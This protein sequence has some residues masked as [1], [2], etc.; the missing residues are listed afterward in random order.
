MPTAREVRENVSAPHSARASMNVRIGTA[1]YAYRSWVG[2]FYPP[3]TSSEKML[4]YYARHFPVVEINNS[5]YRPP[6]R[7]Q[8]ARMAGRTPPGFGFT[9]KAPRSVS[10]DR[11]P[12]DLPAFRA[13]CDEMAAAGK[14][15]GVLVQVP[16]SFRDT[17]PNRDWLRQVRGGLKPHRVAVEFRHRSWAAPDLEQWLGREGLDGVSVAVPDVPTLFPPGLRVTN[18]HIY[19]RLHSGNADNWYAG[20]AAR[21]DFDF[22]DAAL[23]GW[24]D[25]LLSAARDGRADECLVF[26]N[27]CVTTRAVE[28]ARRLAEMLRETGGPARVADAPAGPDGRSLFDE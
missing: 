4:A 23:R 20:G 17:A 6:T 24:A 19:L 15:L 18:R 14:L 9:L 12:G 22:P 1:G 5:F 11:A 2:P 8:A 7:A 21:Y 3:G 28:N 13:A 27:N 10:H 25:T 16:E 26:F